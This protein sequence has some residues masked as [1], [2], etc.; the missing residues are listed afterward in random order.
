MRF[1][2]IMINTDI[3]LVSHNGVSPP[4]AA[5]P[6]S[7]Q[8]IDKPRT[9]NLLSHTVVIQY[10]SVIDNKYKIWTAISIA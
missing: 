6:S 5:R 3:L 7:L 2:L 1:E 8:S 9:Q 4:V 10:R